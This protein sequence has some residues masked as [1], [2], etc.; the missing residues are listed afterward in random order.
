MSEANISGLAVVQR[1]LDAHARGA[2]VSIGL[3]GDSYQVECDGVMRYVQAA[4]NTDLLHCLAHEVA[5]RILR[6]RGAV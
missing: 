5:G 1:V 2:T 3:H 4:T 6:S